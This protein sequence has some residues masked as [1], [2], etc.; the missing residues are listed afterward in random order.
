MWNA[1][2]QVPPAPTL[3]P[4]NQPPAGPA[5]QLI[6]ASVAKEAQRNEVNPMRVSSGT[7]PPAGSDAQKL[8]RGEREGGSGCAAT[9]VVSWK[10]AGC[11]R[12]SWNATLRLATSSMCFLLA[13]RQARRSWI[14]PPFWI[15]NRAAT[16]IYFPPP[17]KQ[18]NGRDVSCRDLSLYH[19]FG[20]MLCC[21][22]HIKICPQETSE[23]ATKIFERREILE[24]RWIPVTTA[25]T[26][27]FRCLFLQ[28]P[29]GYLYSL[30][31]CSSFVEPLHFSQALHCGGLVISTAGVGNTALKLKKEKKK[32]GFLW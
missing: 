28:H 13:D 16:G 24:W 5:R 7:N 32:T 9:A 15:L 31:I 19:S 27:V 29:H 2:P 1:H 10:A 14:W 21:C 17:K 25:V 22:E 3:S 23:V 12:V 18:N 6:S 8:K 30:L 4:A 26:L 20:P 11:I